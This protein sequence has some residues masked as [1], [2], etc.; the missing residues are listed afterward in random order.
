MMLYSILV[1]TTGQPRPGSVHVLRHAKQFVL[2]TVVS[3]RLGPPLRRRCIGMRS[4]R[5]A[6]SRT[7]TR[8]TTGGGL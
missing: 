3:A 1:T 7:A 5:R 4:T 6:G 2:R 8:R